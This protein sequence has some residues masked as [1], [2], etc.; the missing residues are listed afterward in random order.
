MK[1]ALLFTALYF[2]FSLS[3]QFCDT[4]A[5]IIEQVRAS[6][7]DPNIPFELVRHYSFFNPACSQK[8]VLVVHM[9]G[10]FASPYQSVMFPK[11]AGNLGY[12]VVSLKYEN[13]LAAQTACG[14]SNDIDCHYKFRKEIID[15]EDVSAEI[16]VDSVSSIQ[17]RLIRLLHYMD[18]N[19]PSQNWGQY[20]TGDSIHW[21]QV[22][23]SGHSQGGGHAAV[24]AIDRPVKRV[25]MFASPNDYS[26][27]FNQVASWTNM[28]HATADSAYYS[29]N[30][31]NDQVAQYSWQFDAAQNLGVQGDSVLVDATACPYNWSQ[32]LYTAINLSGFGNNHGSVV[33]D[34]SVPVDGSGTSIFQDVWLYL[35]GESCSPLGIA[36]EEGQFTMY[37]N[38]AV[39]EINVR[40]DVLIKE[41]QII[42]AIGN[43][44]LEKSP[45]SSEF[46]VNLE[47]LPSGFYHLM[48]SSDSKVFVKKVV[49]D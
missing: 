14:T 28:P 6:D 10:T 21:G 48:L 12:H 23:L 35:L 45:N 26:V 3:A 49:K 5:L 16:Q 40:S 11:M 25:I 15:G 13:D 20:F 39:S 24:M 36:E 34:S 30:N 2:S 38:P 42:N 1:F 32:N 19:N 44:V 31:V 29:F 43:V 7:T 4:N 33:H 47:A 46:Q 41:Y 27:N 22:V 9:V 18:G 8:N 37:P 17:N